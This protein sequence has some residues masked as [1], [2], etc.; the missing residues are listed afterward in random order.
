MTCLQNIPCPVLFTDLEGRMLDASQDMVDLLLGTG[1]AWRGQPMER[2]LPPA[3]RAFLQT[4]LWPTLLNSGRVREAHLK[5]LSQPGQPLPVLVN[6]RLVQDGGPAH[7]IWVF[8]VAHDRSRFEAEL[9]HTRTQ[10]QNLAR[11]LDLLSQTDPLTGLG[12]RRMLKNA[13]VRWLSAL[14]AGTNHPQAQAALLM[15]DADHFK[16]INDRWGH[17]EGDRVLVELAQALRRVTR[18]SDLVVRHGGEEFIVWLPDANLPSAQRVAEHIHAAARTIVPG[19]GPSALTV[20]IGVAHTAA[21]TG[22]V[23]LDTL[24]S[25]ADRALYLAKA[26]GRN[27]TVSLALPHAL[28]QAPWTAPAAANPHPP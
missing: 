13:F 3:G 19:Q 18:R 16:R 10:A 24:V 23:N 4:H 11:E 12:N 17:D 8:F 6:A 15:V 9:I 28:A 21:W 1:Q 20:S 5:L 26:Q 25:V 2:L 22:P 14:P 7:C 27:Q